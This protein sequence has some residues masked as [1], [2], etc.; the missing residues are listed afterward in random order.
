MTK[1]E[2][3]HHPEYDPTSHVNILFSDFDESYFTIMETFDGIDIYEL[4]HY[5]HD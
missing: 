4:T 3:Y 2:I 5:K 1:N